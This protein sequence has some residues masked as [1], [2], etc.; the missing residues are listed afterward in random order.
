MPI[1]IPTVLMRG[2]CVML[3]MPLCYVDIASQQRLTIADVF[4]TLPLRPLVQF[5]LSLFVLA[6]IQLNQG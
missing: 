4:E 5:Y 6:A 2:A 1:I 3:S